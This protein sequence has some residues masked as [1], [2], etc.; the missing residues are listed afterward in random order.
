MAASSGLRVCSYEDRPEAI[1][2]L[3]LMAESLCRADRDVSLHITS[4]DAPPGLSD[5]ARRRPEVTLSIDH[6]PGA[7]G[8]DIKARLLLQE[9]DEG[10]P[11]ALWL[12]ADMIITRSVSGIVKEFPPDWLIVA[13]EWD[14][15]DSIPIAHFWGW[16]NARPLAPVNSCF[17][18]V[19]QA[20]RGILERW[21]AM[22]CDPRYREAQAR[23]FEERPFHLISDQVLLTAAL[24]S[25]EFST[26]QVG[27]IRLG[28][29]IAQC[30]GSSGY[31]PGDRLLGVFRGLPPIIHCIG[32]K[33]WAHPVNASALNR[34]LL[35]LA[36]DV[37]PYVLA[38]Q[39][40]ARDLNMNPD[41]LRP[42]TRTGA[43]LRILTNGH[44][45]MAGLPLASLHAMQQRVGRL[46]RS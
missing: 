15:H 18:R 6:V 1:D 32:R 8:W 35:D 41:W 46:I 33:P 29:H 3:I 21:A 20:H 26:L 23:P 38:A 14:R 11:Q 13:E 27:S 22:T 45:G 12:D 10:V 25:T 17:V 36:T 2:S 40:I 9:L 43:A 31:G 5:W 28:R 7:S 42:H 19:T 34:Y 4:P 30:A 39:R 24:Q 16:T 44:P 37:S